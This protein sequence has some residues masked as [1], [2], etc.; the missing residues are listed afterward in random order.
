MASQT[1]SG[2]SALHLAL[3]HG[4]A[5]AAA[6]LLSKGAPTNVPNEAGHTPLHELL[7]AHASTEPAVDAVII[8]LL[9]SNADAS[10]PDGD[11]VPP[12]HWACK[13]SNTNAARVLVEAKAV[14]GAVDCEG[15]TALHV[16]L[17]SCMAD[18]TKM[19]ADSN[20]TVS[21]RYV[22]APITAVLSFCQTS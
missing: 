22:P 2:D 16:L 19:R 4:I 12:L 17:R 13:T 7:R 21:H 9:H 1:A 20:L 15:N 11:G 5:P 3:R 18:L 10:L 14:A 6:F 8:D